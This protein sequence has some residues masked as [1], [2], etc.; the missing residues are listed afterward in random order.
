MEST[1]FTGDFAWL[2]PHN[3]LAQLLFS[4][5]YIYVKENS[6]F[7]VKFVHA[8]ENEQVDLPI[9]SV[10]SGT[11]YDTDK[12]GTED[13]RVSHLGHFILSFDE[14]RL[15]EL[16]H[17]G[18]RVGRGANKL[19]LRGVDLLLAMPRLSLGKSLASIHMSFRFHPRSGLLMLRAESPKVPVEYYKNGG[20]WETLKYEEER[21]MHQSSTMLRAGKCE[22]EL[23][24]I[25]GE[26]HR[27]AYLR[28]RAIFFDAAKYNIQRIR[29]R[30]IPGDKCV[31]RGKY[32]EFESQGAGGF[33][34]VTQGVDTETGEPVAIKEVRIRSLEYAHEVN[35]EV[36][37][38]V[39]TGRAFVVS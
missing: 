11:E 8:T 22:Y 14:Q 2:V 10:E 39:N 3:S 34:W 37:L 30:N 21:V 26:E 5:T 18:W 29:F 23:K 15:P 17:L 6:T 19:K 32:L 35:H 31:P 28:Q 27:D 20:E 25:V 9:E 16:P 4:R 12:E 36:N 38:E 24:Y 13:K 1:G 33:G 7:H